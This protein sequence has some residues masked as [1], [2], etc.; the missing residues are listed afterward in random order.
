MLDLLA[1]HDDGLSLVQISRLVQLPRSTAHR[2]LS[3]MC[4]LGYAQFDARTSLWSIGRQ[5]FAVGSAF[6]RVRDYG[7]LGRLAMRSVVLDV[8]EIVNIAVPRESTVHF[9]AQIEAPGARPTVAR[10]GLELPMHTTAAGKAVMA[11]W[12]SEQ[13]DQ[14]LRSRQL[15]RTTSRS[16][17]ESNYLVAQLEQINRLG[18]S[19][20]DEENATGIRCIAAPA[21]DES[22]LPAATISISGWLPRIPDTRIDHLG[23]TLV[24]AARRIT[25]RVGGCMP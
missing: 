6:A 3:T 8:N 17:T 7:R 19:V 15:M 4:D 20:D 23:R 10:P 9:L 22:G 25:G 5:A 24:A 12:P 11:Y 14:F 1:E 18:Y 16:I 21:F 13:V 2:L